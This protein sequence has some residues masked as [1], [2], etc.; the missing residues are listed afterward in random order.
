MRKRQIDIKDRVNSRIREIRN[1]K[2]KINVVAI[3]QRLVHWF[4]EPG[5]RV[6]FPL[7]TPIGFQPPINQH[8]ERFSVGKLHLSVQ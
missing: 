6:R 3:A 1:L 5:M 7:A 8:I 2:Y 4:V